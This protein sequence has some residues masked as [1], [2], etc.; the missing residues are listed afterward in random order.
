M[1][2][3]ALA[4][5]LWFLLG[6]ALL[7]GELLTPGGFYLI[8]FGAGAIVV[9]VLKLAGLGWTLPVEILLF[10][11]ASVAGLLFFRKPLLQRFRRLTPQIAVDAL[12]SEVACSME[13][14]PAGSVGKVELRG[15]SWNAHNLDDSPIPRAARCRVE[16]VDGLTLHVRKI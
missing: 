15:T 1:E 5:W 9:G 7:A 3:L 10:V 12:T 2:T 14:I 13:E 8:F 6:L 4:W 16:R 11:A